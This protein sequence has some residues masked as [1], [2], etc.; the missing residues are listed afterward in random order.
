M[1]HV[2]LFFIL[3]LVAVAYAS[4]AGSYDAGKYD[5]FMYTHPVGYVNGT[6]NSIDTWL[7]RNVYFTGKILPGPISSDLVVFRSSGTQTLAAV[8]FHMDIEELTAPADYPPAT[9]QSM[10]AQVVCYVHP[11]YAPTASLHPLGYGVPQIVPDVPSQIQDF[12]VSTAQ[13]QAGPLAVPESNIISARTYFLHPGQIRSF[14]YSSLL[15]A[16]VGPIYMDDGAEIRIAIQ[17]NTMSGF[18]PAGSRLAVV[19]TFNYANVFP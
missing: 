15:D 13:W 12:T 17:Y 16:R 9:G 6:F 19:G 14:E 1:S 10:I 3:A 7:T 4:K 18:L 5:R 11:S 2:V 8:Q